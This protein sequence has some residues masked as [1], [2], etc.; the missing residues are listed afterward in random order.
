MNLEPKLPLIV[1]VGPT[2]SGK[3]KLSIE[4]AKRFGG[5]IISADSRAVYNGMDIGT[6]KPTPAERALVVHWGLDLINP[7]D[8]FSA[9]DF[10]KYTDEKI[11]EIRSRGNIPFLVG[12]TGL[13]I[14]S[15]VF[16]YKFGSKA[17]EELRSELQ[18]LSFDE[19]YTY[20][21][22]NKIQLPENRKNK[23]YIIRAIENN[24]EKP[25]R[26]SKPINNCVIVGITTDK[27]ILRSRID[28]R[29]EKMFKSGVV[30]ETKIL[31]EKF[32]WESEAMKSNIYTI[33]RSLLQEEMSIATSIEKT[34]VLDWRLAK[35]QLTWMRRNKFI[36]WLSLSDAEKYISNQL[37]I[38]EQS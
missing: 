7:G 24:G 1:I 3:T 23:R 13:Y 6:A 4:L 8:Y 20:C 35:R 2:A 10:K 29:V 15:V 25:V 22:N 27:S 16:D 31:A 33:L 30:S 36:H 34:K 5:E 26:K 9:A 17:N 14:D 28:N 38:T 19:L 12:G 21:H 18:Q 11:I 32:G 37:A